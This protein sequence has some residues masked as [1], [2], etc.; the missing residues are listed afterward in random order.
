MKNKLKV[1]EKIILCISGTIILIMVSF[2]IYIRFFFEEPNF[3][4]PR[5]AETDINKVNYVEPTEEAKN[6]DIEAYADSLP[7]VEYEKIDYPVKETYEY[8]F[9]NYKLSVDIP[10][11]FYAYEIDV[12]VEKP[13][14]TESIETSFEERIIRTGP[15][16]GNRWDTIISDNKLCITEI[17]ELNEIKSSECDGIQFTPKKSKYR[18]VSYRDIVLHI[19][20]EY[21]NKQKVGQFFFLADSYSDSDSATKKMGNGILL[22]NNQYLI[23]GAEVQHKSNTFNQNHFYSIIDSIKIDKLK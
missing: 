12:E 1:S 15:A 7:E 4:P 6:F 16:T 11:G 5:V 8:K 20:T 9:N 18:G 13:F 17:Q 3:V 21:P 10:E 2:F 22:D 14:D 19:Y 23:I